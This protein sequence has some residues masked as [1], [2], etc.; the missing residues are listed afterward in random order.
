MALSAKC[1]STD[2]RL[3]VWGG[4]D[5]NYAENV[6]SPTVQNFVDQVTSHLGFVHPLLS[7]YLYFAYVD[8]PCGVQKVL[9]PLKIIV[10]VFVEGE[11]EAC[12][13]F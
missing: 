6:L 4:G 3:Y 8:I 2:T 11:G 7:P 10:C 13:M 5:Y 1:M 12:S 9:P